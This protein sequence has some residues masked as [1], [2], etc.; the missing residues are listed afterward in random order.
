MSG[1]KITKVSTK[2]HYNYCCT[3]LFLSMFRNRRETHGCDLDKEVHVKVTEWF[4]R[5]EA[6]HEDISVFWLSGWHKQTKMLLW[7]I[8]RYPHKSLQQGTLAKSGCCLWIIWAETSSRNV[9]QPQC[10]RVSLMLPIKHQRKNN[11]CGPTPP[12][13]ITDLHLRPF[14][15]SSSTELKRMHSR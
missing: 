10:R 1:C 6:N 4:Q 8:W 2:V 14:P 15:H 5:H 12:D 3:H 11:T 9:K 7:N 13:A